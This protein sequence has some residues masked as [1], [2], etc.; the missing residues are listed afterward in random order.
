[1]SKNT[2]YI[3]VG[4]EA[5]ESKL[6][7]AADLGTK[8]IDEDGLL[9]LIKTRKGKV[10]DISLQLI[11]NGSAVHFKW[12]YLIFAIINTRV[13]KLNPSQRR[14]RKRFLIS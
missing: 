2:S 11:L 8:Q 1:M 12:V 14:R 9:D 3:V 7:K 6:K 5:G 10:I 4:E 13:P